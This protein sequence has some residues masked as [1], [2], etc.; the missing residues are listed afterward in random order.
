MDRV[1]AALK[2]R[3]TRAQKKQDRVSKQSLE[4]GHCPYRRLFR[5][6]YE[7]TQGLCCSMKIFRA[8]VL[9]V[10]F[11]AVSF[12]QV[13]F[14]KKK[15]QDF[16]TREPDAVAGTLRSGNPTQR[17]QLATE[18]DIMA[19]NFSDPAAKSLSLIHISSPRDGLLSR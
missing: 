2:R 13:P 3:T 17:S 6:S 12:A 5:E 14:L 9:L 10:Y 4:P 1:H 8:S 11:V 19:P 16:K 15:D 7:A 18:L